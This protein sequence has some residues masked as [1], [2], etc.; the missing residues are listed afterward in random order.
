MSRLVCIL[1]CISIAVRPMIVNSQGGSLSIVSQIDWSIDGAE[2]LVTLQ[3]G[4]LFMVDA[5]SRTVLLELPRSATGP[6]RSAVLQPNGDLIATV[7]G[8]HMLNIWNSSSGSLINSLITRVIPY[9]VDWSSDGRYI[10]SSSIDIVEIRDVT[11][12]PLF[13]I[14]GAP[15]DVPLVRLSP[16]NELLLLSFSAKIEVWDLRSRHMLVRNIL[17]GLRQ[18]I[19]W[20]L[21]GTA[22][23]AANIDRTHEGDIYNL[24]V[25]SPMTG[26]RMRVYSGFPSQLTSARWSP[27]ETQIVATS[28]DGTLYLVDA[29]SGAI[30]PI[31]TAE[32]PLLS[33]AWSP[34]GGQVAI[35][36]PLSS[37]EAVMSRNADG[38]QPAALPLS[39]IVPD[40]SPERLRA[41]ARAC[42]EAAGGALSLNPTTAS[43]IDDLA[44]ES[45]QV[46]D[47]LADDEQALDAL[48]ARLEAVPT[49]V[50]PL[51]CRA[52]LLAVARAVA[53]QA[54]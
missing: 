18:S 26:E 17:S 21:D 31:V 36:A 46:T 23:L 4:G 13:T 7:G 45:R 5:Y 51:G 28:V 11:G 34:F 30:T 14:P 47:A 9:S 35:G 38:G 41:V 53:A 3:Q 19:E 24:V 49:D 33:A 54:E 10:V 12:N 40:P 52:D 29:A 16:D 42:D 20:S 8:D 39:I 6:I 37:G 2:I 32:V 27:D 48:I 15:E 43:L 22:I 1:L 25:A 44:S 50:L